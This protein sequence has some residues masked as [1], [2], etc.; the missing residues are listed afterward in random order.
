MPDGIFLFGIS[1]YLAKN[2]P[3]HF[4]EANSYM[5]VKTDRYQMQESIA[6]IVISASF[7]SVPIKAMNRRVGIACKR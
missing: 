5:S 7:Q 6:R 4:V 1:I 2:R 3:P